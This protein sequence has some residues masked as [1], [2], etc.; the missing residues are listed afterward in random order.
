MRTMDIE[1][2][3]WGK[4]KK[5][6]DNELESSSTT[7]HSTTTD[8]GGNTEVRSIEADGNQKSTSEQT[9]VEDMT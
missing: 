7:T 2:I 4:R 9:E 8:G 3:L 1:W 6:E 5:N